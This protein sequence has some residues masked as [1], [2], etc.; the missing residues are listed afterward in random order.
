MAVSSSYIFTVCQVGAEKALKDEISREHPDLRFA[1][2]RPGFVTF[3]SLGAPLNE[4]FALKSVFAR[5][6]GLSLGEKNS[7]NGYRRLSRSVGRKGDGFT[8]IGR[9]A[10]AA[11]CF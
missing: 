2:S 1:F 9:P 4:D 3:K 6:Y 10:F 7:G 5:A 8:S 11:S